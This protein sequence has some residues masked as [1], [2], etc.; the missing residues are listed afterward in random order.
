MVIRACSNV[1]SACNS[2]KDCSSASYPTSIALPQSETAT[3]LFPLPYGKYSSFS[4]KS[5]FEPKSYASWPCNLSCRFESIYRFE[6][7]IDDT[8]QWP[9]SSDTPTI[10]WPSSNPSTLTKSSSICY[11]ILSLLLLMVKGTCKSFLLSNSTSAYTTSSLTS[12]SSTC[13][14]LLAFCSS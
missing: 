14:L 9:S 4:I 3:E 7:S 13:S 11:S 5:W 10:T 6:R 8:L 12:P 2:E 1:G